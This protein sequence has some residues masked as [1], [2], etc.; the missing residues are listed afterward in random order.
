MAGKRP[1]FTE[2]FSANLSAT[3]KFLAPQSRTT[4]RRFLARLF[5]D[6]IPTLCRFPLS[7]RSFLTRTIKST[8]ARVLRKE[9]SKLLKKED[10]LREFVMD[11]FLVLYLVR[12]GRVIFL[13]VKHHRQLSFDLKQFWHEE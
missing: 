1:R 2:N 8:K 3:E 6:A 9:M 5:D 11:E 12:Q 10:D 13:A 7:G 4:F